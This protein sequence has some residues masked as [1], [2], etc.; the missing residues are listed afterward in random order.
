MSIDLSPFPRVRLGHAP[1]P[2]DHAVNLSADTG[3]D[4]WIKRDDCTGLAFGGNKVRQLEFYMGEAK[5]RDAD[6]LLI[7]GAVQS[8]FMRTAAAAARVLGMEPHLQL[9][10]RVANNSDSYHQSGNVHLD[11]LLGATLYDFEHGEDEAAADA[12][13]Q[14]IA[15]T[16]LAEGRQPYIIHLGIDHP[17]IGGLGYVVAAQEIHE[18]VATMDAPFDAIVVASGSALTHAGLLAGLRALGDTTPVHGICVRRAVAAQGPRVL[19]RAREIA[20]MLGHDVLID[21]DDINVHDE[22]FFPGYGVLNDATWNAIDKAARL[23]ALFLDPVYTG[24]TLAG[25]LALIEQGVLVQDSRVL[26]MHTGGQPALFGY[27]SDLQ[28]RFDQR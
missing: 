11:R 1:T 23:E 3:V 12:G 24:R 8:N 19:Q 20:A 15:A 21:D 7:T 2:I 27:Q 22:V 5:A 28:A 9:E 13:L 17:P 16:L 25:C 14:R 4:L 6:T 26:L 10:Q 18:Q